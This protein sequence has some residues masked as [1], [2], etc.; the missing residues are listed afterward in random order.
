M[1]L[2]LVV[3]G[4]VL[5]RKRALTVNDPALKA[6]MSC[7]ARSQVLWTLRLT[8]NML[9]LP[10]QPLAPPMYGPRQMLPPSPQ[11]FQ[12]RFSQP[13]PLPQQQPANARADV[14]G[15]PSLHNRPGSSMSIS[16]MLGSDTEKFH[17]QAQ[18]PLQQFPSSYR[19]NTTS[20]PSVG[21]A[22]SPPQ[23]TSRASIGEYSYKPRSQ[24]PDRAGFPDFLGTRQQRSSSGTMMQRP[25]PFEDTEYRAPN[26]IQ[27]QRFGESLQTPFG[28]DVGNG[29]RGSSDQ[30][31][32]T[33]I[34]GAL[35]R[36]SSQP[37]PHDTMAVADSS[38]TSRETQRAAW[39]E[40]ANDTSRTGSSAMNMDIWAR[41]PSFGG[42][43]Q[44]P[45][46][47]IGR[48]DGL[49]GSYDTRPPIF[50]PPQ[51]PSIFGLQDRDA[52][53]PL[54]SRD[55]PQFR[56][57]S[58]NALRQVSHPSP[59]Q[60][61]GSIIHRQANLDN[62]FHQSD[63]L[64]VASQSMTQQESSQSQPERSIFG[65]RIDK[66]RR[67]LFSPFGS[68][69]AGQPFSLS[70]PPEEQGRKA[71]DDLSQHR[72]I[73][74]LAAEGKRGG[75]FSPLPQAVQGAQAQSV[76]P[77]AAIKTEHGRVFS[78]IGS[79]INNLASIPSVAPPGLSASPFK[80]DEA[81]ARNFNNDTTMKLSRS[82]PG[83]S[84][85]RTRKPKEEGGRA[86]IE[87][88][89]GKRT[90]IAGRGA[91]RARSNQYAI[92]M[93]IFC[94]AMAF[95]PFPFPLIGSWLTILPQSPSI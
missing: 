74:N 59:D 40:T 38:P 64:Q 25:G 14:R 13:S 61:S 62:A 11:L 32:R 21:G 90:M 1:H 67:K 34:S 8:R 7:L 9:G 68:S 49:S 44:D 3:S 6:W 17:D 35:Q 27:M 2:Q 22:M 85:R 16:S 63:A 29:G 31:R 70:A 33:S 81:A 60:T 45:T 65:E 86:A 48:D 82:A 23:H 50:G 36:P 24:T 89:S 56:P 94:T 57:P 30:V 93:A 51:R 52:H 42:V 58:P 75:R 77:D 18:P 73:L 72:A 79:G 47:N 71:S 55:K 80:R 20:T 87:A 88:M 28:R 41:R 95:L 46:N 43:R 76:G 26:G 69:V 54:S 91:K 10:E 19:A 66:S 53:P 12:P 4:D 84:N 92:P 83:A 39:A 5:Q 37:H 15:L 78:G